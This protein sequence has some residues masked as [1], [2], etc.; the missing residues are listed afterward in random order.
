MRMIC[1]MKKPILLF[2]TCLILAG[3]V[4][5][6]E[7]GCAA[8]TPARV[9]VPILMYHNLCEDSESSQVSTNTIT[10]GQFEAELAL[11]DKL[12]KN[13]VTFD[14]LIAYV[15]KGTPLPKNPVCLTF[16]DGYLSNYEIAFPILQERGMKAT[17]FVIGATV[18]N[19]EHYKETDFPIT[20]HFDYTEAKEMVDSG[21]ISIQ[22]HTYDMHQWAKY[23]TGNEIRTNI[24]KLPNETEEEYTLA[25][26]KDLTRSRTEIEEKAGNPVNVLAYPGGSF[27]DLSQ[28]LVKELGIKA[29]LA[30]TPGK[31]EL[32]YGKRESLFAM[33]RFYVTDNT[34]EE[35]FREW[36]K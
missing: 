1:F 31:A 23:E 28:K 36:L 32:I 12:G 34:T 29:T 21:L 16:D 22:S 30:I 18:G 33:N 15:E 25:V 24:L 5:G 8:K 20:P 7:A 13:T 11:L 2:F 10:R 35:I 27:D 17:I 4:L 6:S 19:K 9:E 26:T 14:E 3:V